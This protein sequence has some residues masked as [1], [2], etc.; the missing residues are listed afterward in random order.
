V[1][2]G[3][4]IPGLNQ[5]SSSLH[6]SV[7]SSQVLRVLALC[8]ID[9]GDFDAALLHTQRALH[10]AREEFAGNSA[11]SA[12]A[13]DRLTLFM[14][15]NS[16]IL[17][18]LGRLDQAMAIDAGLWAIDPRGRY[19]GA[20][21]RR[22]TKHVSAG[23]DEEAERILWG[24]ITGLEDAM[25]EN[26]SSQTRIQAVLKQHFLLAEL[27]ERRGTEE[28]LAKARA[29]RDEVAQQL[30]RHEARRAVALEET[31]TEAA[32]VIRQWREERNKAREK[33]K[34]GKG[35]KK[36][37][38][39]K[40]KE[41]KKKGKRPKAKGKGES[42][43]AAIEA[44]PLREPAGGEAEGDAAAE[45]EQQA[46]GAESE[47]PE[48]EEEEEAREECAICLQDL[49]LEDDE[50]S[51]WEDGGEGEALVV[52]KCGHRFHAI[53]GDMW[54]AKC[55]DKGWGV[56]CPGCRAPYMVVRG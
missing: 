18:A 9:R 2:P 7:C 23:E 42:S 49:E 16:D 54:C 48:E 51:S 10:I 56:T 52:L 12:Y 24:V 15:L 38:K 27:L 25:Y 28:A 19:V 46:P 34:G 41:G 37:G 22:A 21:V 53:C 14:T 50:D 4:L 47:A 36:G 17:D 3:G 30:A 32:E 43:A 11:L 39:G 29:V 33:K 20:M 35:K 5:S 1:D 13:F 6:W 55:A 40:N 31:R 44:G 45:A 8:A 26:C